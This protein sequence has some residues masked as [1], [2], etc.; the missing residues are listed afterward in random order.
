M[1]IRSL[2]GEKRS[3]ADCLAHLAKL[4]FSILSRTEIAASSGANGT[5]KL[6]R[7]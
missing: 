2:S 4:R 6:F 5:V 7:V 3:N 1:N